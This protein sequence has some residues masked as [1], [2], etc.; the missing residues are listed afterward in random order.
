MPYIASPLTLQ[1]SLHYKPPYITSPIT[2]QAPFLDLARE[3]GCL[4]PS[5]HTRFESPPF[6]PS[7]KSIVT[8][9]NNDCRDEQMKLHVTPD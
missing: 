2:L 1:V 8:L 9:D 4:T 5:T 3:E 7:L 6:S